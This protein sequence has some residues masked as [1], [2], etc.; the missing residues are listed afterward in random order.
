MAYAS[1]E[2]YSVNEGGEVVLDAIVS[3]L[4]AVYKLQ[5]KHLSSKRQ[6]KFWFLNKEERLTPSCYLIAEYFSTKPFVRLHSVLAIEQAK[7]VCRQ[8]GLWGKVT[9][10]NLNSRD[11]F[12]SAFDIP[13]QTQIHDS[14]RSAVMAAIKTTNLVIESCLKNEG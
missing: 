3:A 4:D 5:S 2:G 12:Q 11:Q 1:R 14:S 6:L 9:T 8:C 13:L 10:S 7:S